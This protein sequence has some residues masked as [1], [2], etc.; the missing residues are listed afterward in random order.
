MR[1][2]GAAKLFG[3]LVLVV[4]GLASR[5]A[6][7]ES[8]PTQYI[9]PINLVAPETPKSVL[10][11]KATKSFVVVLRIDTT[12][13]VEKILKVIPDDAEFT[14]AVDGVYKYWAFYPDV[15]KDCKPAPREGRIGFEFDASGKSPRIW[16]E[17]PPLQGYDPATAEFEILHEGPPPEFPL[18]VRRHRS[19]SVTVAMKLLPDESTA[20]HV[21][22]VEYPPNRGYRDEALKHAR[23]YRVRTK[24]D[25]AHRFQ[26]AL[27]PYEF[28]VN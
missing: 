22:L 23:Q 5:A 24:F 20:E 21:V 2:A 10:R 18:Q 12:G 6:G 26:C 9:R 15:D 7:M 1:V 27:V 25:E 17:M 19:G 4:S 14:A 8:D 3:C 16:A 28:N 13:A 11:E